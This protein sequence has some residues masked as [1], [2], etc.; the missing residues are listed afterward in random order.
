MLCTSN[1]SHLQPVSND[2][3][4]LATY[5][6][7]VVG[8]ETKLRAGDERIDE[9]VVIDEHRDRRQPADGALDLADS[10]C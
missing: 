10:V 7:D 6:A 4:L 8:C 5:A 3:T 9:F 1:H 2:S